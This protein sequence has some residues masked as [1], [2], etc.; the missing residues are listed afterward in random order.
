MT[1]CPSDEQV[2]AD[3]LNGLD[4]LLRGVGQRREQQGGEE[5]EGGLS[6]I[7]LADGDGARP[8]LRWMAHFAA[9]IFGS[10]EAA[11]TVGF[12]MLPTC[13]QLDD[14]ASMAMPAVFSLESAARP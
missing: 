13:S 9:P 6:S 12:G 14:W 10:G 7:R 1:R 11:P 2:R 5:D 8:S 3:G 4:G